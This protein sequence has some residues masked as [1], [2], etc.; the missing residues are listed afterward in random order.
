LLQ[1]LVENAVKHGIGRRDGAGRVVL[2]GHSLG[3]TIALELA[4]RAEDGVRGGPDGRGAVRAP[5]ASS[6]RA[7][8]G[9]SSASVPRPPTVGHRPSGEPIDPTGNV[10]EDRA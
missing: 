10:P 5:D 7:G 4:A 8:T 1:P 3:G 9:A 6:D 2:V